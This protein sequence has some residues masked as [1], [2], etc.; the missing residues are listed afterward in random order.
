MLLKTKLLV[1]FVTLI[2]INWNGFTNLKI[3]FKLNEFTKLNYDYV[4][5]LRSQSVNINLLSFKK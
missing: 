2:G 1:F 5:V 3:F 4:L